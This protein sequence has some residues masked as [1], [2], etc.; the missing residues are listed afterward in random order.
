MHS[1]TFNSEKQLCTLSALWMQMEWIFSPAE[2]IL[3]LNE[4]SLQWIKKQGNKDKKF[5]KGKQV[6]NSLIDSSLG[7][8][9]KR[10]LCRR[11]A[12]TWKILYTG[13]MNTPAL[14]GML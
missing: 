5:L 13:M 10:I 4:F 9:N 1:E 6:W 14:T 8:F 3:M 2:E 12:K 7:Q 11:W